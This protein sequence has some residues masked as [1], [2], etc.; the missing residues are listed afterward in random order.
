MRGDLPLLDSLSEGTMKTNEEIYNLFFKDG[1][2]HD[3][4]AK[5]FSMS[6]DEVAKR[7]RLQQETR[8]IESIQKDW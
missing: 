7:I 2:N 5:R 8:D 6:A 3:E 4:I 1:L